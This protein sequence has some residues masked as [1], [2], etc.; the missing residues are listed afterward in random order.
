[1]HMK[2]TLWIAIVAIAVTAACQRKSALVSNNELSIS[3]STVCGW[4]TGGDSLVITANQTIYRNYK[5]CNPTNATG[6]TVATDKAQWKELISL[7]N[8][9]DFNKIH[10]NLCNVCA[11][12]CDV[13]VTLKDKNNNH[14]ISYG[15][16]D[17]EA[18]AAIRPFLEKM[19]AIR[20]GYKKEREK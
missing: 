2:Y 20:A 14:S 8:R 18:V 11:D 4:C 6:K 9:E 13:R 10:L 15:S 19:E 16:S 1:M 5:T 17:N 12:G 7:L 3:I